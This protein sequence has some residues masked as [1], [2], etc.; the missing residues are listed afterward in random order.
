[1]LRPWL[2]GA[3]VAG[4]AAAVTLAVL[5]VLAVIALLVYTHLRF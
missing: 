3:I 4:I 5:G 1:M 2:R